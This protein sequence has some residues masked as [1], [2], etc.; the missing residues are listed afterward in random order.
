MKLKTTS[1][2]LLLIT[3]SSLLFFNQVFAQPAFTSSKKRMDGMQQRKKLLENSLIKNVNFKSIGPTVMSGRVVDLDVNPEDPSHFY[4]GFASGGLWKTTSNGMDMQPLFQHQES[5][6]VGDIAVNWKNGETIWLG[7][8]ENNSS[9]S[10]YAGTGIYKSTDK[11]ETWEHLG[12]EGTHHIGRV[13]LHPSNPDVVWVAAL[14]NLYSSNKDRG[15]YKTEDGGKSWKK[16]LFINDNTGFID[17]VIDPSNPEVLYAASWEKERKAWDF[18][19]SGD[20]SDIYKTT[21]GGKNWKKINTGK[22]GFPDD[23]GVGRI[24][25]DISVSNSQIIYAVLD[26]Q[27]RRSKS[28]DV[29][30]KAI[31]TT[32]LLSSID[33]EA[34]INLSDKEINDYLDKNNFPRQYNAT[35]IKEAVKQGELKPVALVDYLG[36]ANTSL[37]ET[38]VIG[39]EIYRSDDGGNNWKKMN[40]DYIDGV[41][42]SYGYYFGQ[43]RVSPTNPDKIYTFGVPVI[44]SEDAGKTWKNINGGNVHADHHAL[45]LNPNKDGHLVLGNDGGVN[46]SYDDGNSWIKC[47]NVPLG[48]F[49]A[50]NYDLA[51]PYN[52]YGGLQDNGVWYGSHNANISTS[53]EMEGANPFKELMGG[54]GMQVEIDT[55][56]NNI[57]YAGFQFGYYF[58]INKATGERKMIQP[59][60]ELGEKPLR[61]NWQSPIHLSKHNQ[62][63]LYFGSNKFHRSLNQGDDFETLSGD[64]TN[65]GKNGNVPYGTLTDINESPLKFGLLYVGTDDGL[66]HV[67]KDGGYNW[68]KITADLPENMWVSRVTA[69]AFSE[70]R[71][72]LSLNGYRWDNFD[73]MVYVSEDYGKTWTAIGKDLPAESVNVIKEDPKNENILYVG[74]D[75]GLYISLDRGKSFMMAG[76]SLPNVPVHDL[77]IHPKENELIVGTHGRSIYIADVSLIQKLTEDILSKSLYSFELDE[78]RYSDRWGNSIG[79]SW[80]G[81]N[82][83]TLQIP[84][85]VNTSGTVSIN[86]ISEKGTVL[87]TEEMEVQKGLNYFH[88]DMSI[89]ESAVAQFSKELTEIDGNLDKNENGKVYLKQGT[90]TIELK[91]SGSTVKEMFTV[92]PV[93]KRPERKPLEK[94][95]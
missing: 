36:D 26:N 39:T 1:N 35:E 51:K 52:V 89:S 25:L 95:P 59:K 74:T 17:L 94:T 32:E 79:A 13:I 22:N 92:K 15:I 28:E 43:I 80:Y 30:E 76:E 82:E 14:G 2:F 61:F 53:W 38:P 12:L 49:Y 48:Q 7:S 20:G 71:V 29:S 66:V 84:F 46:I 72:Y 58:R 64:L 21:D 5:I 78:V 70:S 47:N 37:F 8:G 11:G 44:K 34:F 41:Y 60:H 16:I 33:N 10:S 93:N 57:V 18:V 77:V 88:Y 9:R 3:C 27:N 24:G 65:G 6:T 23:K 86:V 68:T 42:Y 90:Y 91:L 63:I 56:N 83:P 45:W 4:I 69:S 75:H 62:D 85:Y 40:D 31:V 87:K 54:D 19:G 50:V 73:A 81:F 67:S 55:R